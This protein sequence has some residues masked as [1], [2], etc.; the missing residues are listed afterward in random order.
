MS[1]RIPIPRVQRQQPTPQQLAAWEAQQREQREI[2]ERQ[3]RE[4]RQREEQERIQREEEQRLR[5]RREEWA[6]SNTETQRIFPWFI[7]TDFGMGNDI[8]R[9]TS[10]NT[11]FIRF[12]GRECTH[13]YE[14][15]ENRT[16]RPLGHITL[17][18]PC[19]GNIIGN[20]GAFHIRDD[21][22]GGT[23]RVI[24]VR[25]ENTINLDYGDIQGVVHNDLINI[26][27]NIFDGIQFYVNSFLQENPQYLEERNRIRR[28]G[29][30]RATRRANRKSKKTRK[31]RH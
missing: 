23:A 8:A 9:K 5:E 12:N 10:D 25:N 16:R 30:R 28:G 2:W 29:K 6:R 3:Q 20:A 1:D 15:Y 11:Y 26:G 22:N 18:I 24:I 14:V 31:S 13:I 4:Q 21:I 19:R 7:F 17:H 27:R